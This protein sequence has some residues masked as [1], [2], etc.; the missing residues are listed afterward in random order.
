MKYLFFKQKQI[1]KLKLLF[2]LYIIYLKII[3]LYT[4]FIKK[5]QLKNGRITSHLKENQSNK[6]QTNIHTVIIQTQ[7]IQIQF[8]IFQS[9]SFLPKV[10]FLYYSKFG[11][12]FFLVVSLVMLIRQDLSSFKSWII[13]F[14]L[15][16]FT[17]LNILKEYYLDKQRSK[18]DYIQ[19]KQ[20]QTQFIKSVFWEELTVGDVVKIQHGETAPAD[21][22]LLDSNKIR[23]KQCVCYIDTS[24]VDGKD[25]LRQINASSLTR[26]INAKDHKKYYFNKYKTLLNLKLSYE[27]PNQNLSTFNGQLRLK[28]DPKIE[29][30]TN[31]N[32]IPRGSTVYLQKK[33]DWVYGL[34]IYTGM[35]TKI[36]LN[37]NY[38]NHKQ[39]YLEG[40]IQ[41]YFLA[42]ICFLI[43]FSIVSNIVLI[44]LSKNNDFIVT[45]V[46]ENV[47]NSLRF[48]SYIVL[49][50]QLIPI[51]IH[52]ILDILALLQQF[53]I[54]K[55]M[56]KNKNSIF[57]INDP[58]ILSNL[59]HVNYI[60]FLNQIFYFIQIDYIFIDKQ[61]CQLQN[62]IN[63]ARITTYTHDYKI[64]QEEFNDLVKGQ[65][66]Q[67]LIIT[68][69]ICNHIEHYKLDNLE[70]IDNSILQTENSLLQFAS[71]SGFN[72]FSQ[73]NKSYIFFGKKKLIQIN[74]K[75]FNYERGDKKTFSVVV[76]TIQNQ[77]QKYFLYCKGD[78]NQIRSKMQISIN[79][80]PHFDFLVQS[81][82]NQGIQPIVFTK[83]QLTQAQADKYIETYRHIQ[84]NPQVQEEELKQLGL[85]YEVDLQFV[86]MLGFQQCINKDILPLFDLINQSNFNL[87]LLSN[88]NQEQTLNT[89]IN[90]KVLN[91]FGKQSNKQYFLITEDNLEQV[92]NQVRQ[93]LNE[94]NQ[95][96]QVQES[97]RNT[98]QAKSYSQNKINE[99]DQLKQK[100]SKTLQDTILTEM[101]FQQYQLHLNG[102]SIFWINQ[103]KTLMQHFTFILQFCRIVIGYNIESQIKGQLVKIIKR[104]MLFNPTVCSIGQG[105]KDTEMMKMADISIELIQTQ[106]IQS[107]NG[108]KNQQFQV[109]SN[110]GD[111]QLSDVGYLKNLILVDGLNYFF[112]IQLLIYFMFYKSLLF[113]ISLF[114]FNWYSLFLGSS[115]FDSMW[116][117]LYDFILNLGT[118]FLYGIYDIPFQKTVLQIF[119]SLYISGQV[120]K[121][122][123]FSNFILQSILEGILQGTLIYYV[124]IYIVSRSLSIDGYTSDLGMISLVIIY[125]VLLVFNF[126]AI[127]TAQSHK[128]KAVWTGQVFC[129]AFI[130]IFI[131]ANGN[132]NFSNWNWVIITEEIFKRQ[133]TVY[134]IIYNVIV[135]LVI[136]HFINVFVLEILQPNSYLLNAS[137]IQQQKISW[138]DYNNNIIL[139]QSIKKN[140]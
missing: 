88:E 31:D 130:I 119:P 70:L 120:E 139:E 90:L 76:Q 124:S 93:I 98:K 64:E 8:T 27:P 52:G 114:Y 7:N 40:I 82:K 55:E 24:N 106:T 78:P 51:S 122:R 96:F 97:K 29:Y 65:N 94:L 136:T 41:Y 110:G 12:L 42:N 3:L 11:N 67:Q 14:T 126:K 19:N 138:K 28:K 111:I 112:R 99:T 68:S 15:L 135:C 6:I 73:K 127:L 101:R 25:Q 58:S 95:T 104:G 77:K 66:L 32:F 46:D 44:A 71:Q 134:C 118:I 128:V 54:Q 129:L 50:S 9:L 10:L 92:W 74:E 105:Y 80:Y 39:S 17:L 1:N 117:F 34:V 22:I 140:N 33:K 84:S 85:E 123:V 137:K 91:G 79:E 4:F 57:K 63:V 103:D 81:F 113:G 132:D 125:S 2:S 75:M 43:L 131:F 45:Y 69:L 108:G 20:K 109:I 53:K 48:L 13:I 30:L 100:I 115:L 72:L 89:A 86:G 102:K 59:G 16:F 47:T 38:Q 21:M 133:E 26:I 36:M 37:K 23:D 49:Y 60:M 56:E 107:E 5:I 61:S 18:A 35:K 62:V 87:Y 83:K 116:V 121:Q